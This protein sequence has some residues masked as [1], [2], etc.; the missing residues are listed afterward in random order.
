M[1]ARAFNL[2]KGWPILDYTEEEKAEGLRK[3]QEGLRQLFVEHNRKIL[4]KVMSVAECQTGSLRKLA[5]VQ[6]VNAVEP[7]EGADAIERIRVL[8]WWVVVNKGDYR[9]GDTVVY[10]EVDSFLPVREEFEFLR[11]RCFREATSGR[12][13]GFR[14]KTIRLRGQISQGIV[15]PLSI[16]PD[17]TGVSEGDDVT[18]LLGV[19]KFELPD[20]GGYIGGNQKGNFPGFL[21]K[22]DE[23]RVQNIGHLLE[24]HRG[25]EFSFTEKLD[26]TSFTAF[27]RGG[28]FGI[29][30]RN[31]QLDESDESG[32]L[33]EVARRLGVREKLESFGFDVAIQG[34][35]IGP[36]I[37]GNKYRLKERT[38]FVFNLIDLRTDEL[39][40][41]VAA[42]DVGFRRVPCLGRFI[43][44]HSVDD[45]VEMA[46]GKS[47]VNPD[48]HREGIVIRP[49]ENLYEQ[50][51]GGRFSFKAINPQFLLKYDE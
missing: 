21:T 23:I 14:V 38:L 25:K 46:V 7:I 30:S 19:I 35:V 13:A 6:V 40:P 29:C 50:E 27:Y 9:V 3:L 1:V 11:G 24:R 16:L 20:E 41:L 22:T 15:F 32:M 2:P 43:L 26:G 48:V 31:F 28:E 10:C 34:E 36:G 42:A 17:G 49:V 44:D 47:I 37:Q 33:A 45:I 51:C 39:M 18:G 8:G 5:S 12:P 4:E